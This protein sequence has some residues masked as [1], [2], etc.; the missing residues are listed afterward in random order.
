M[1]LGSYL[2]ARSFQII[3]HPPAMERG[4]RGEILLRKIILPLTR[5][6]EKKGRKEERGGKRILTREMMRLCSSFF[7][8]AVTLRFWRSIQRRSSRDSASS[9]SNS[10]SEEKSRHDLKDLQKS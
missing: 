2:Y 5:E 3:S 7:N 4:G 8:L 10:C 9:R 1:I 6:R